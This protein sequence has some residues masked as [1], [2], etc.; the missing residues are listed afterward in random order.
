MFGDVNF[1]E[2]T[3][4]SN[5]TYTCQRGYLLNSTSVRV[6]GGDGQ[7]SDSA[8]QCTRKMDCIPCTCIYCINMSFKS[9][10]KFTCIFNT[11]FDCSELLSPF[12]GQ[13]TT[14]GTVYPIG[15][16]FYECDNG[17]NLVGPMDRF[18]LFNGWSGQ[19]PICEGEHE[20]I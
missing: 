4:G 14:N 1:N 17:F 5:A 18:C 20:Q 13:V 11:A 19:E 8:P 12:N 10:S 9:N 7:W 6:C 2:T 15:Y 3:F 16:A